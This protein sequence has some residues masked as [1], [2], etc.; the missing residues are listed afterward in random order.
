MRLALRNLL[1]LGFAALLLGVV[2]DVVI[3]HINIAGLF[4]STD[5]VSR[6]YEV[7]DVLDKLLS[8]VTEAETG[9]RGYI[10]TGNDDYLKPY[11]QAVAHVHGRL[12]D[13]QAL[14]DGRPEFRSQIV[15]VTRLTTSKLTELKKVIDTFRAPNGGAQAAKAIIDDGDGRT[16]M[17][18][19][20]NTIAAMQTEEGRRLTESKRAADDS[21]RQARAMNLFGGVVGVIL[22]GLAFFLFQRDL[23][24]REAAAA[25]LKRANDQLEARVTRRTEALQKSTEELSAEVQERRRAEDALRSAQEELERRVAERTAELRAANARL[26]DADRRKDEFLAML[27]H[28]LRNPLAPIRNAVS[29]LRKRP[30][31]DPAIGQMSTMLDRQVNHLAQLVDDLMDVARITSGKIELRPAP[32]ELGDLVRRTVDAVRPILDERRHRLTVQVPEE[33]LWVRGDPVR[34]EQILTNLVQNAAK[35]TP[36]G[37]RIGISLEQS[38]E[39]AELRVTDTGMGIRPEMLPRIF[40]MFQ[41]GDRLQGKLIEGLG[42]GLT[43]VRNLVGLHGGTVEAKSEGLGRGSEFIIR[44]PLTAPGSAA[45]PTSPRPERRPRT[46]LVVDDNKDAATSLA[47][48]LQHEGHDVRLAYDGPA[49]LEAV[50]AAKP[51]VVLL[52]IGMPGMDGY[53]VARRMRQSPGFD[54]TPIIALTGF[55]SADDHRR[56]REAGFDQHL[57]KPVD[58]EA[59]LDLLARV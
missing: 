2:A 49:A 10:L 37:G 21:L 45:R 57:T 38:G 42:I 36:P 14:A 27:A 30:V 23:R 34:L 5:G 25:D 6:S 51:Q 19:L 41:Q 53:E 52:D 26:A 50:A 54:A 56:S 44:L 7:Q 28:E 16:Y 8:T 9:Q 3:G 15:E 11:L 39:E 58:P 35:Y 13:V 20:R 24:N 55:G 18:K 29:L 40:D 4:E 32:T 31:V 47:A 12:A 48:V 33:P 59:L 46:V 1:S 22:V 43:L 17:E